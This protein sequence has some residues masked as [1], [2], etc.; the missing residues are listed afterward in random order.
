MS[1]KEYFTR[2]L[3]LQKSRLSHISPTTHLLNAKRLSQVFRHHILYKADQLP[4]K[5]DLRPEM[6]PVEDQSSIGSR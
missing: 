2:K 5:V 3:S 1:F 6:T 4:P